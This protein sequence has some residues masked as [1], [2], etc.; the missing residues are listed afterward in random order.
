MNTRLRIQKKLA[1]Q[2]TYTPVQ[3]LYPTRSFGI[4]QKPSHSSSQQENVDLNKQYEQS[5]HLGHN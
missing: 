3:N 2:S 5:Q 1:S 4:Q